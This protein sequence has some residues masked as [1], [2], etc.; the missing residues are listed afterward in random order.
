MRPSALVSQ[1]RAIPGYKEL[2]SL[3]AMGLTP[4]QI[5]QARNVSTQAVYA[6]IARGRALGIIP[7]KPKETAVDGSTKD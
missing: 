6:R 2:A 4:R 1:E 7:P 5:A 3:L